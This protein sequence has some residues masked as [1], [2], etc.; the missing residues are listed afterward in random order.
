MLATETSSTT[1][2]GASTMAPC[3][4]S[5]NAA[6]YSSAMEPPSLWPK[7]QTR[8]RCGSMSSAR[9]KAGSTSR[10]CLCM[11]SGAQRSSAARGVERP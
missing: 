11:K 4:A 6:A 2:C 8:S 5:G 1:M 10:A 3:S 9:S 7:S